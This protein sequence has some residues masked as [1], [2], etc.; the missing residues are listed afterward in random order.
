MMV[1]LNNYRIP[2]AFRANP[3]I[4]KD[5]TTE[6]WKNAS[7]IKQG[8]DGASTI[9]SMV[10]GTRVIISKQVTREVLK[11][12]DASAFPIEYSFDQVKEVLEKMCYDETYPPIIKKLLPPYWRLLAHYFVIC[13]SG[14]KGGSDE[15]TLGPNTFGLMKQSR[16]ATKFAY[17]GLK[18]LVKFGKFVEVEN[19]LA[20]SS[21]NAEVDE[22][23]VAPKPKFQF[24]F[25]E[26]EVFDDEA[27][28]DQ[29]KEFVSERERDT[30][31]QS[32]SP[33]PEYMDTLVAELQR[34]ARKP[35]QIVYVDTKP[36]S[37]S[38]LEKSANALLPRKHKRRDPTLGVLIT[39]PVQNRSTPIDPSH[40]A[41]NI[42]ITFNESSPKRVF[43]LEQSSA[44][45]DL[46]IGK[47]DIQVSDIEKENSREKIYAS[48]SGVVDPTSQP[49]SERVVRPS[50]DANL[51]SFLSS[52]P[53]SAQE[54]RE[55]QIRVEQLKGKM[56][57]MKHSYQNAPSDHPEMFFRKTGKKFKDKYGDHS[58][59][60]MWG[61]DVDKR[62]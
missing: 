14:R 45:K 25:E 36:P 41:R 62:M 52:G 39:D 3:V 60:T 33:T 40:V 38:D 12:G 58:G 5:L 21:S 43:D 47:Q 53:T 34:T 13:I 59:I 8:A 26:I 22:E 37:G 17:Q 46:I 35:P 24:S 48:S 27:E 10:K 2:Q 55:K 28:E 15:I 54:R 57:V 49:T 30:M 4:H 42:E 61:Y 19:T 32:S 51:D 16:K 23:H 20:A 31:V 11:F 29:E 7:I 18:K 44:E 56:L 1:G 50:P 9:G 6:F